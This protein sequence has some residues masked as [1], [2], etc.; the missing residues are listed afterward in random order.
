M[1]GRI[2]GVLVVLRL[3]V[4]LY[5]CT[6]RTENQLSVRIPECFVPT[7]GVQFLPFFDCSPFSETNYL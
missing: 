4:L 7:T 2:D 3:T 5:H 6:V 1:D